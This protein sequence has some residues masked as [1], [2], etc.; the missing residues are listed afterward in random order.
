MSRHT[1]KLSLSQVQVNLRRYDCFESSSLSLIV[2]LKYSIERTSPTYRNL[3]I[4]VKIPFPSTI[5]VALS[6]CS[7]QY[8]FVLCGYLL[9]IKMMATLTSKEEKHDSKSFKK[10]IH[11]L[12]LN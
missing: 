8:T 7:V 9:S 1:Q 12:S 11:K 3:I 5:N 10:T 6:H 2:L 4:N